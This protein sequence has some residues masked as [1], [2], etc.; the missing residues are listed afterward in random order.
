[1]RCDDVRA[2]IHANRG[3]VLAPALFVAMVV[4]LYCFYDETLPLR[5]RAAGLAQSLL[6][7]AVDSAEPPLRKRRDGQMPR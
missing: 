6:P 3:R 4:V 7:A 2:V 1:M 5:L